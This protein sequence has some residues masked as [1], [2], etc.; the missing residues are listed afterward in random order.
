[1]VRNICHLFRLN[2]VVIKQKKVCELYENLILTRRAAKA[3]HKR[4]NSNHHQNLYAYMMENKKKLKATLK[5]ECTKMQIG[6]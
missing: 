5:I 1:M 2:H 4:F 3:K 6:F